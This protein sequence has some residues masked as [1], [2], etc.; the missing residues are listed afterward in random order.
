MVDA[1]GKFLPF[2]PFRRV[3]ERRQPYGSHGSDGGAAAGRSSSDRPP[4]G[5]PGYLPT[6]RNQAGPGAD[7]T[8]AASSPGRI[9]FEGVPFARPCTSTS[10]WNGLRAESRLP[11]AQ[12]SVPSALRQR[13]KPEMHRKV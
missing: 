13:V 2:R 1:A 4:G 11:P 8:G 10:S 3:R 6:L 9:D 7:G 12:A 5:R